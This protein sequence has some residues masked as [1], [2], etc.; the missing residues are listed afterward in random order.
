[1]A[2]TDGVWTGCK[3]LSKA[4]EGCERRGCRVSWEPRVKSGLWCQQRRTMPPSLSR[5]YKYAWPFGTDPP[6]SRRT[7]AHGGLPWL[8]G[9]RVPALPHAC[10]AR[11]SRLGRRWC[12]RRANAA[13]QLLCLSL[14]WP[15]PLESGDWSPLLGHRHGLTIAGSPCRGSAWM[16]DRIFLLTR[17]VAPTTGQAPSPRRRPVKGRPPRWVLLA[18]TRVCTVL[19][20]CVDDPSSRHFRLSSHPSVCRGRLSRVAKTLADAARRL[21]EGGREQPRGQAAGPTSPWVPCGRTTETDRSYAH[22]SRS[23]DKGKAVQSAEPLC[24]RAQSA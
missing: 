9:R 16:I 11:A 8:H 13:L 19:A 7:A 17:L 3:P 2:A 1:M 14:T 22:R 21:G 15:R 20:R 10:A 18:A 5:A 4:A 23:T 24:F 6:A 12:P